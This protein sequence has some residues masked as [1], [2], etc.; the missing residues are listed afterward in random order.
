MLAAIVLVIFIATVQGCRKGIRETQQ[1]LDLHLNQYTE[2]L[3]SSNH[4]SSD[5]T[6][7][8]AGELRFQIFDLEKRLLDASPD[9]PHRSVI[10]ALPDQQ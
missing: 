9:T 4:K 5:Q 3:A 8:L 2:L 10:A 6:Q 7:P 1:L